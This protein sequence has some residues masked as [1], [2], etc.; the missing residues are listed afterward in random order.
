MKVFRFLYFYFPTITN[1]VNILYFPNKYQILHNFIENNLTFSSVLTRYGPKRNI[2]NP[3]YVL[4]RIFSDFLRVLDKIDRGRRYPQHVIEAIP[5]DD[6][7]ALRRGFSVKAEY[8]LRP[9]R[10]KD[11]HACVYY[12]HACI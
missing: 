12:M 8:L 3:F 5:A 9:W 11:E 7:D 2:S 10:A 1:F 4:F 6:P